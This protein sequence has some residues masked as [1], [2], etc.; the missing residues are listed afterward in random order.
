MSGPK[1][2]DI[3]SGWTVVKSGIVERSFKYWEPEKQLWLPVGDYY[4]GAPA[5]MP[6]MPV[7]IRKGN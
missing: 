4:I 6:E 3:L 1:L 7:L 5:D 2:S